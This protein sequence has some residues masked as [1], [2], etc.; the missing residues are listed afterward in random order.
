MW[1]R[2]SRIQWSK[3]GDKK[4]TFFH[5]F[6]QARRAQNHIHSLIKADRSRVYSTQGMKQEAQQYF[7]QLFTSQPL[8]LNSQQ[9]ILNIL[10]SCIS[11]QEND[12]LMKPITEVELH[13]IVFKMRKGKTLGPNG[14]PI[15]F[16]QTFWGIIK[17]DLLQVVE[18]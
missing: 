12:K 7:Q 6:V 5:K 13:N 3:E 15:K 16:F 2:K 14:F 4:S 8:D 17:R 1:K 9:Q 18:E 10:P 11:Q